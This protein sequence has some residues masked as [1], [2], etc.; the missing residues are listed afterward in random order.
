MASG[1]SSVHPSVLS[2]HPS[3]RLSIPLSSAPAGLLAPQSGSP[4]QWAAQLVRVKSKYPFPAAL[5]LTPAL[6]ATRCLKGGCFG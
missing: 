4:E 6:L 3:G 2:M 1:Q 5:L